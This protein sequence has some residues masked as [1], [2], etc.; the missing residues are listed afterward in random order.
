MYS[1]FITGTPAI[2]HPQVCSPTQPESNQSDSGQREGPVGGRGP[3]ASAESRG[4]SGVRI[5]TTL[6]PAPFLT[7]SQLTPAQKRFL[8][9]V[10]G[11]QSAQRVYSLVNQY[12]LNVLHRCTR[13]G[14]Q[15]EASMLPGTA[16]TTQDP[17][18]L[19]AKAVKRA[20]HK[21]PITTAAARHSGKTS[22]TK[23][24]PKKTR[25]P[26]KV[27]SPN[28]KKNKTKKGIDSWSEPLGEEEDFEASLRESLSSLSMEDDEDSVYG[29]SPR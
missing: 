25:L 21:Q 10:A 18:E 8:G 22:L 23:L 6:S 29:D 15:E 13:P 5:H 12:Y 26:A 19:Q 24:P 28:T 27:K 9:S 7:H 2:I 17:E 3:L 4:T 1:H 16:E 11:S 20:K 14:L